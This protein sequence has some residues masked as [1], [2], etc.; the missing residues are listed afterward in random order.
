MPAPNPSPKGKSGGTA[1]PSGR[2]TTNKHLFDPE[3]VKPSALNSLG[4]PKP[5]SAA[6]TGTGKSY[7]SA[8]MKERPPFRP[9][10]PSDARSAITDV[11][12]GYVGL[13]SP[14]DLA[15]RLQLLER[16]EAQKSVLG[17]PYMPTGRK[18]RETIR[19]NYYLNS[20]DAETIEAE[21]RYI[22][23]RANRNMV[24][25]YRRMHLQREKLTS[26]SP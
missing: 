22:Q 19:V 13:H 26:K 17:G 6:G 2:D 11:R 18:A 3:I 9:C 15:H 24:E 8:P 5:A 10:N 20:A 14:Y 4:A 12:H 7:G 23:D 1:S 21:R 16:A 25:Y